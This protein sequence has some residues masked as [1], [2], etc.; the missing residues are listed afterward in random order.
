M[1]ALRAT[2][3]APLYF[4]SIE[5]HGR[6]FHDGG[7]G[8][9]C[10]AIQGI[11]NVEWFVNLAVVSAFYTKNRQLSISSALIR[12]F[13]QIKKIGEL[14]IDTLQQTQYLQSSRPK[15]RF[16]M[17]VLKYHSFLYKA[18]ISCINK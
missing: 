11:F 14:A 15:D 6:D 7:I 18:Q 4:E 8:A 9:N 5:L 2:S 10:P 16:L 17:M 3:A 13:F 12:D 1:D